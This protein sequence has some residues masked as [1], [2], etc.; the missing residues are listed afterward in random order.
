MSWAYGLGDILKGP[1]GGIFGGTLGGAA[2]GSALNGRLDGLLKQ[3]QQHGL[4][5]AAN[6]WV[7][8]GPNQEVDEEDL[9]KALGADTINQ[10]SAHSG[11]SRRDLLSQLSQGLPDFVDSSRPT[12]DCRP[13]R[14]P[15]IGERRATRAVYVDRDELVSPP[16]RAQR[17][18]ER[19]RNHQ[20]FPRLRLRLC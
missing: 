18:T 16:Q 11:L 6:S 14:K 9:S 8:T 13:S 20:A 2:A 4:G 7:G 1:L 17:E 19:D 5:D 3:L 15:R 10:V 12:G